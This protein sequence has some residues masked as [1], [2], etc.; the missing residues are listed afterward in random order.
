MSRSRATA[1]LRLVASLASLV[2]VRSDECATLLA[3]HVPGTAGRTSQPD[4]ATSWMSGSVLDPGGCPTTGLNAED[5]AA[6]LNPN[7]VADYEFFSPSQGA[8]IGKPCA[9]APSTSVRAPP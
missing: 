7:G 9:H 8:R 5:L 1:T 4:A 2:V 6:D 3:S